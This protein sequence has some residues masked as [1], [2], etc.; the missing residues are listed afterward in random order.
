MNR[1][2]FELRLAE[3]YMVSNKKTDSSIF[4][5]LHLKG[6]VHVCATHRSRETN[7][8][9]DCNSFASQIPIGELVHA[10]LEIK[11]SFY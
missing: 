1:V 10:Q 2:T 11:Y 4:L 6:W 5:V 7:R 8:G 9:P 3:L